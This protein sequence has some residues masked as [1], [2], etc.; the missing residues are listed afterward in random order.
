MCLK[1]MQRYN[2]AKATYDL[3]MEDILRSE[4]KSLIKSVFSLI[5]LFTF[6]EDRDKISEALDNLRTMMEFYGIPKKEKLSLAHFWVENDG[7]KSDKIDTVVDILRERSF[8]KRFS[9]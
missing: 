5:T 1:K 7:W 2:E 3:L 9:K 8:F 6:P 4:S